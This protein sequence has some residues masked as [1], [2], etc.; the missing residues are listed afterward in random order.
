MNVLDA[1]QL[2]CMVSVLDAAACCAC[3]AIPWRVPA[4]NSAPAAAT[5]VD[6]LFRVAM[7]FLLWE[8]DIPAG[9]V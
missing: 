1:G 3:V 7:V 9:K 4:S 6:T 5:C 8:D 2:A